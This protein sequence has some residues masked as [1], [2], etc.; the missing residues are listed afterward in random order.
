MKRPKVIIVL[1]LLIL[2]AVIFFQNRETIDTRILFFTVSMSR[3]AALSLSFLAGLVTGGTLM[4]LR[5]H[6][7]SSEGSAA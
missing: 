6:R 3:A 4:G 1:V 5:R 2:T 7:K